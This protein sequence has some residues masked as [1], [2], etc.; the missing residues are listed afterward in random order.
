MITEKDIQFIEFRGNDIQTI[1]SQLK[2]LQYGIKSASLMRPATIGDGIHAFDYFTRSK[3]IESFDSDKESYD[4]LRFIPASGAATRMFKSLQKLKEQWVNI[5]EQNQEL[6]DPTI[7]NALKI[8]IDI[9]QFAFFDEL[10][11]ILKSANI[12]IDELLENKNYLPILD[13]LLGSEGMNYANLPKAL[14]LFHKYE[15]STRTPV[16]EH[17]RE[18]LHYALNEDKSLKMHFTISPEHED[19]FVKHIK[20]VSQSDFLHE[21]VRLKVNY[22]F[23]K[24]SSDTPAVYINNEL[25]RDEHGDIVFR[26]AGHGALL[27]NLNDLKA[28]LVFIR[29]IDNVA[30]EKLLDTVVESEK[31]LGGYL[32]YLVDKIHGALALLDDGNVSDEDLNEIVSICHDELFIE[33]PDYFIAFDEIEKIDFLYTILNKPIRVCG[34]IKN[35]GEPGGGP[36]FISDSE[37]NQNLQIIESSQVDLSNESQRSIWQSST[38]FNPVDMALYVRDF[39]GESFDLMDFADPDAGFISI[40]NYKGKEIKALELPGLWNGSMSDWISVFVELPIETF[41]PVKELSDLLREGH[42]A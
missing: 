4:I 22:S 11:A 15:N 26:P 25:V 24:K 2:I 7:Q 32:L 42:L 8:L 35:T 18:S 28:E 12:N 27:E 41:N 10:K 40:K 23:Q 30:T 21:K 14:L 6:K 34:M 3:Y 31:L 39:E 36:F 19:L 29:N 9:Q 13:Y 20:L 33:I 17:I 38:H 37:G 1:E 16:E 5:V